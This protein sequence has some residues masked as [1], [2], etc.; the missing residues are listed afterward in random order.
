M[1][2]LHN[3]VQGE[4]P[5]KPLVVEIPPAAQYFSLFVSALC[6][7]PSCPCESKQSWPCP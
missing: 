7:T 1:V 3:C 5:A 4:P 6:R 2:P